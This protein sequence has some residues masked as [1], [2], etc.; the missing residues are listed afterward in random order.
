[1]RLI[2]LFCPFVLVLVVA[3]PALADWPQFLGPNRNGI[4]VGETVAAALPAGGFKS[5]WQRD[6]GQGFAGVAVVD[7]T[8][9]A[10]HR[11]GDSEIVEALNAT[12]GKPIWKKSFPTDYEPG[13]TSDGGPRCVPTVH[14]GRVYVFGAQGGLRCLD[15]K[16]GDVRW[17]KKTHKELSAPEGFFGAGST[18]VIVGDKIIANV[19][20]RNGASV[21]A[22]QLDSGKEA[23][24]SIEDTAS[25]SS[26]IVITKDDRRQVIA[27]SR[28][29]CSSLDPNTGKV[30]WTFPFGMRGPT[31][32]GAS[33]IVIG[34]R[35]FVTASYGIG[36][37]LAKFDGTSVKEEWRD[38]RFLATQYATPILLDGMLFAMDGRQDRGPGSAR[39]VCVDPLQRKTNWSKPGFDYGTIIAVGDKL[40]VLTHTGKLICVS[41]KKAKY[42]ELW[43]T[44]VLNSSARGYRM[45]A[46]SD[47]KLFIRDGSKLKCVDIGA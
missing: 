38:P 19:G 18:P 40:L 35:V 13:Y 42:K 15:A 6:V 29:K 23:W 31:V 17:E 11:E 46:I 25:Y 21:V 20:A 8:V 44:N 24:K 43:R 33:P 10:F 16:S 41:A 27:I 45:P 26:P 37:V 34:D 14:K 3:C 32:N 36:S 12:T 9:F 22:F 30:N 1:M 28:M 7:G 2:A 39:L 4:A 5:V 47:G